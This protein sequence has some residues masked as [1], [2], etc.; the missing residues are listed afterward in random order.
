[1]HEL[2]AIVE[3][4]DY[5]IIL[6]T[7]TLPKNSKYKIYDVEYSIQ[8]YKMYTNHQ[9]EK[10]GRG[11]ITYVKDSIISS[12]VSFPD[13]NEIKEMVWVEIKM[14]R[15]EKLLVG[16]IYRSPNSTAENNNHINTLLTT[17]P[18]L[19]TEKN[20]I[21]TGDFNYP[22]INWQTEST[23]ESDISPTGLFLT[24]YKQSVL[25]QLMQ[26]KT[27][28][29]ENQE[30]STLDLLLT[31]KPEKIEKLEIKSPIGKS[32]HACIAFAWK[33]NT[34]HRPKIRKYIYNKGNYGRMREYLKGNWKELLN[35]KTTH[36]MA[37][38]IYSK[39]K[40]VMDL[41]IPRSK[42]NSKQAKKPWMTRQIINKIRQRDKLCKKLKNT[43]ATE[44]ITQIN[45]K[46]KRLRNQVKW[47]IRR[48]IK[49]HEMSLADQAKSNPKAFW[50]YVKAKTKVKG[51]V[52]KLRQGGRTIETPQEIAN[53][54]NNYFASVFTPDHTR[55]LPRK[56]LRT[57]AKL[58]NMIFK[59]D[60]IESHISKLKPNKS[61]GPD[62]ISPRVL[63][64]TAHE[65]SDALSM[66]F[67]KSM[68]EG[69]VP[70][71][72]KVAS[73]TPVH[74]KGSKT[75]PGN[76]RP[77]SL[78]S[79][80]GKLM[81]SMMTSEISNYLANNNLLSPHQHG[82][83]NGR[84]TVTNLLETMQYITD[85]WDKK[86][87]IHTIYTDFQ[88]AFD[89]VPHRKLLLKLE[90]YGIGDKLLNW[91]ANFLSKRK[92]FVTIEDKKSNECEVLSGVP[93][94]S[95]LGPALFVLYINDLPDKIYSNVKMFA[96]DTKIYKKIKTNEDANELQESMNQISEW[97][98]KWGMGLHPDKCKVM[99]IGN[100]QKHNVTY[101]IIANNQL[102]PIA[103]AEEEKDLGVIVDSK[104][105]FKKHINEKCKKARQLTMLIRRS[106]EYLSPE[107]FRKLYIA[108]VRPHL[109]YA[110][111]IWS[112]YHNGE[113][114]K[115]EKVQRR[116]TKQIQELRYKTYEERL[117]VLKLPTLKY[118]RLRGDLIEMY[119]LT[120][121]IYNIDSSSLFQFNATNRGNNYK[122][123]KPICRT[124]KRKYFF[125]NRTINYWNKLDNKTVN[126][127]NIN[128]LKVNLDNFYSGLYYSTN[129]D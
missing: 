55:T 66:L 88:K 105:S 110:Q 90:N 21:I 2:R 81:E 19:T 77:V 70:E 3:V 25:D 43:N 113:I 64:E 62:E 74:K 40:E 31:T 114:D 94:G 29:R 96:D 126:S 120:H 72:W 76:Y 71:K 112:P 38:I 20:I 75:D 78:T 102:I 1:M 89:K 13:T 104:I 111:S 73:V 34:L 22:K 46:Y 4:F 12:E 83:T 93:Q 85:G 37:D 106:F 65:M 122:I 27:R 35:G 7:E 10:H 57:T 103:E 68:E 18:Q 50:R 80:L 39:Y 45:L 100:R 109:E 24:A 9:T 91:I 128:I 119:K 53:T 108:I 107:V 63:K 59:P 69:Q 5:D 117:R 87:E 42:T 6:I 30:D 15:E 17:L 79:V 33:R 99:K 26:E 58:Y 97:C 121:N 52:E 54:L 95:V 28:G 49:K 98:E 125:T 84:S 16:N 86:E 61:P 60:D 48:A 36:E 124:D 41:Y 56:E 47:E 11:I 116:A 14:C 82:F 118:R 51:Q 23:R 44:N 123:Y 8:G 32:D 115:I 101:N 67:N 129:L 92:Q 127:D